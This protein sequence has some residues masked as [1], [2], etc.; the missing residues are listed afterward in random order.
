MQEAER[1]RGD[2]GFQVSKK[3]RRFQDGNH[4]QR[5]KIE[6]EILPGSRLRLQGKIQS[7]QSLWLW[8]A[9]IHGHPIKPILALIFCQTA[10]IGGSRRRWQWTR[11]A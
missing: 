11:F 9:L 7:L 2:Q 1:Q 3:I 4:G 5:H 8:R 6:D 10:T